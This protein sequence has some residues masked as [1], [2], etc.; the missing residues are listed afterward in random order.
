MSA[1]WALLLALVV[2]LTACREESATAPAPPV[3]PV[4]SVVATVQSAEQLGPFIGLIE[5]RYKTD[6]GFR[7]FGRMVA[8][9]VDVGAVVKKGGE[10][11]VLDPAV[12]TLAVRSAE[13]SLANAEAQF[14]NAQAEEARL[15]DL[16]Q[17]NIIPQAQY[18]LSRRNFETSQAN[19]TRAR[20]SLRKAQDALGY[21]RLDADFDG[22][23]TAK[24]AEPG[25]VLT[26]GQK[27]VTLARPEVR[28]A[29]IAVPNRIAELLSHPNDFAI[30][31]DLDR[32]VSMKAAG[33]RAIDP[34]ADSNT[35]TRN[36]Y[37]TLNDPPTAFRLGVTVSVA[38]TR[39]VAPH[40]DLPETA[41]LEKDG[42]S[43]VWVVEQPKSTVALRA[44]TLGMREDDKV[45][46]TSGISAGERIVIAGVH[47][48]A[49]GEPVKVPQ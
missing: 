39:P 36:V 1:A 11:A 20:A 45:T 10:I 9:F 29:V 24:W 41:I 12:Q 43:F 31:V 7:I 40:V 38:F 18:D 37:L 19:V 34:I 21:T 17:R 28:E 5:P 47:S 32:V 42:K 27:V 2:L 44:V 4:L 22:V 30:T 8:R 33:I 48:L 23:V 13:A 26:A 49:E 35:R 15:K 6:L 46:V 25:Q 14:V 3:R 16:V